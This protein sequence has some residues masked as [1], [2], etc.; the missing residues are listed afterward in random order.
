M[1][2]N[3]TYL[4]STDVPASRSA[5]E[6]IE[7][8]QKMGALRISQDYGPEGKL[9]GLQ[10]TLRV[11]KQMITFTLPARIDQVLAILKSSA[12][13]GTD[14]SRLA[15]KAERIAWRQLLYWVKAQAA[16]IQS[17]M[18]EADEVFMPYAQWPAGPN[19]G[20]TMFQ[21]WKSQLLLGPGEGSDKQ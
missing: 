9:V 15:G 8:L 4:E 13:A 14:R 3:V 1:A 10:W 20:K 21:V 5:A 16:M 19:A 7:T 12:K 2:R 18:A 17:G 6:L 11:A